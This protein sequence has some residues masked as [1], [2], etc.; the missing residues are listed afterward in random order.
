MN[1]VET[2]PGDFVKPRKLMVLKAFNMLTLTATWL[3]HYGDK[4]L[5][6]TKAIARMTDKDVGWAL[7]DTTD[8]EMIERLLE[9]LPRLRAAYSPTKAAQR[10]KNLE[11]EISSLQ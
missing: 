11:L 7:P 3:Q 10:T 8:K 1:W 4:I 5:P 2:Y 6:M 9:T